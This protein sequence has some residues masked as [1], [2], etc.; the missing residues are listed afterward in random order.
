MKVTA[1]IFLLLFVGCASPNPNFNPA[2]PP[3]ASNPPSVPNKTAAGLADLAG[4][5]APVAPAPYGPLVGGIGL[6]IGAVAGIIA[7]KNNDSK[8]AAQATTT[9]LA[10]SVVAQGPTV[11]QAV[12]DHASNNEAVF[13]AVANAVNLKTV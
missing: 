5:I 3:S 13:P 8:I 7:K 6:L 12:L 4:Q 9:Q 1:L 11:A 2:L 10:A